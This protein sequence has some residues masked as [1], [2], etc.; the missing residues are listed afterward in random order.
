MLLNFRGLD[1]LE[2]LRTK[3]SYFRFDLPIVKIRNTCY[4]S[5]SSVN[6]CVNLTEWDG[7]NKKGNFQID[8]SLLYAYMYFPFYHAN[9]IAMLYIVHINSK[10]SHP[11]HT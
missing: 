11:H 6:L 7:I 10:F 1:E 9:S 8:V 3:S 2:L 5:V 4:V